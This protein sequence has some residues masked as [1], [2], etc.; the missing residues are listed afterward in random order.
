MCT[1]KKKEKRENRSKEKTKGI[2][3]DV[4]GT[5]CCEPGFEAINNSFC[6]KKFSNFFSLDI[7]E[8]TLGS[9]RSHNCT[10]SLFCVNTNGKKK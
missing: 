5:F 6:L 2:K 3:R 8:C 7:D 1:G 10:S 9:I 4:E